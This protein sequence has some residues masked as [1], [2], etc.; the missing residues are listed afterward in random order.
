MAN[1]FNLQNLNIS[2]MSS[3]T[4]PSES[5]VAETI[6]QKN[7]V[8]L[9]EDKTA[10]LCKK[11]NITAE[12]LFLLLEKCQKEGLDI[13]QL[14]ESKIN[15]LIS[16]IQIKTAE[17]VKA[18][19][20][21]EQTT[22][23]IQ[24]ETEDQNQFNHQEFSKLSVNEKID[25]Y[26]LELAKNK[27][28]FSDK[29]NKKSLEDWNKLSDQ[30][31]MQL[32]KNESDAL[33]N[34]KVYNLLQDDEMRSQYLQGKMLRLQTASFQN[35]S[36]DDFNNQK[37]AGLKI[38]Q[39]HDYTD[40]L[41]DNNKTVQLDKLDN[42]LEKNSE[43]VIEYLKEEAKNNPEIQEKFGHLWSDKNTKYNLSS[44]EIENYLELINK[45]GDVKLT[46]TDLTLKVMES[47]L[48][49]DPNNV[50]LNE[51]Y[52][53]LSNFVQ[54][55]KAKNKIAEEK[56]K[57][58]GKEFS[59]PD[60]GRISSIKADEDFGKLYESATTVEDKITLISAYINKICPNAT[61]E[62][63][64]NII[65]EFATDLYNQGEEETSI[66][67]AGIM[68]GK[69]KGSEIENVI[70]QNQEAL[71]YTSVLSG[72]VSANGAKNIANT[73]EKLLEEN[74]EL[75]E[76]YESASQAV[77][78][79]TKNQENIVATSS[80]YAVSK[81]EKTQKEHGDMAL[82]S[83]VVNAET[84]AIM[85]E[86][87]KKS[88]L[89]VRKN[90][91]A[92]LYKA[93]KENQVKAVNDYMQDKDV[94]VYMN[95]QDILHKFDKDNQ[96]QIFDIYKNRFEQNDFSQDEAVSNLNHLSDQIKDCDS[97]NQLEMHKSIMSSQY[98]EVQTHAAGNIKNYDPSVQCLAMD[99]VYQ[100]GNQKAIEAG[101][102]GLVEKYSNAQQ[103]PDAVKNILA[104]ETTRAIFESAPQEAFKE[105][106][107]K[108][109]SGSLS[110]SDIQKLPASQKREYYMQLFKQ[111]R[112]EEKLQLIKKVPNGTMKKSMLKM[113]AVISPTF[114]D[115]MITS[116]ADFAKNIYEMN[117]NESINNKIKHIANQ[118]GVSQNDF[119]EIKKD[120]EEKSYPPTAKTLTRSGMTIPKGFNSKEIFPK[121]K[122]GYLLG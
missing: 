117:L 34:D 65:H 94:A 66:L 23:K 55:I 15:E 114:F 69:H 47:A 52:T 89:N 99:A 103:L 25:V 113:I 37:H 81:S 102:S 62:E 74:P 79:I 88:C 112:P 106:L 93:Y 31:K 6:G 57:A 90:I 97:S 100:T 87:G 122:N 20:L 71:A 40:Q 50:K 110:Y 33:K 5:S 68:L 42:S 18:E 35:I 10:E 73:Q 119:A 12:E 85:L 118:K 58:E 92:N 14:P 67:F 95:E 54:N 17:T 16:S 46:K 8:K 70:T 48:K 13:Y 3:V 75:G 26:A 30:E 1:D 28:L 83:S 41:N 21:P 77:L 80:I 45:N 64:A 107:D 120:I 86:N 98:E 105:F 108:F 4:A 84:Q 78:K 39:I 56:A 7:T 121:D 59:V 53:K 101:Y 91:G 38:E 51:K 111:A 36:F 9:P 116:D 61:P 72:D 24:N 76:Q 44:Q 29:N 2:N 43:L 60:L 115:Y 82:D 49:K 32:A 109:K 22:Q 11:Y 104:Q 63:K 96:T 27:F 19:T